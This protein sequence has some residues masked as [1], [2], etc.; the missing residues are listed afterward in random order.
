MII[1]TYI[2]T[3]NDYNI[4]T[5]LLNVSS[6]NYKLFYRGSRNCLEMEVFHNKCNDIYL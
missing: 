2:L 5:V 1:V 6:L 4:I 3:D